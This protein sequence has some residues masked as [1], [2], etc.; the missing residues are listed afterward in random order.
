MPMTNLERVELYLRH[1]L[2]FARKN[3]FLPGTFTLKWQPGRVFAS[4]FRMFRLP[5]VRDQQRKVE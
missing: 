1:D 4:L 5:S 2:I 3:F